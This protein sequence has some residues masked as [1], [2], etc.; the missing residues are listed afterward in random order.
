MPLA[1]TDL[2][3]YQAANHAEDDS[4][5]QGGAIATAG[6]VEFTDIP[7]TEVPKIKSDGADPR[8]GTLTVRNSAGAIVA[9]NFTLNGTTAVNLTTSAERILKLVLNSSDASRTVTL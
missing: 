3:A 6:K 8:T 9:D 5:T 2:K 4:S 1:S 7:G